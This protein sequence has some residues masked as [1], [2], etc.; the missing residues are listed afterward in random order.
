MTRLIAYLCLVVLTCQVAG[1]WRKGNNQADIVLE[2]PWILY[3]DNQFDDHG[4]KTPVLV[5]IAPL[6]ATVMTLDPKDVF[7]PH[8]PQISAGKGFCVAKRFMDTNHI[9]CL[10]FDGK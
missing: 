2:G 7:H 5:A 4:K 8:S 6:A 1:C 3:Q 10:T 9:F